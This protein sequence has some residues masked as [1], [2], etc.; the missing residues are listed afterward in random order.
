MRRGAKVIAT[1]IAALTAL[2]SFCLTVGCSDDAKKDDTHTTPLLACNKTEYFDGEEIYIAAKGDGDAWVG[3]YR[4]GDDVSQSAAIRYY[5]VAKNGFVSGGVYALKKASQ[6]SESRQALRN[7]PRGKYY[8]I[9]F[10]S[11]G[12]SKELARI[13]FTVKKEKIKTPSAPLSVRYDLDN[14][15]D[16]L[17]DGKL[18]LRFAPTACAEE[19]VL[20]WADGNGALE[21]YTALAPFYVTGD[22]FEFDMYENTIIPPEATRLLAYGKNSL[23][24]S[25]TYCAV[26]LPSG[27]QYDF[28]DAISEFQVVSDVHITVA[29]EHIANTAIDQ[30]KLHDAHFSGMFDDIKSVSPESGGV[31]VVG[32]IANAGYEYEW[33]HAAELVAA[34][35]APDVYFTLGNHDLYGGPYA[36]RA[37][38]FLK[39]A[40]T[41]KVYY[42][43][44]IDGYHH[45]ALG[46]ESSSNGLDA[47]LSDAQLR[48]FDDRLK[49]I[50]EAAPDKPVF[51][52]LHQSLYNTVAGSFEGQDW[53]GVVQDDKLRAIVKKYPQICMFNGHSH[54]DLNT[55]GSM[56]DRA[57]GLPNIFNTASVGYLWTSY[58]LPKGEYLEGS[59]GYY[60]RIFNGK[61]AVLGRDFVNRKWVPSACFIAS[62]R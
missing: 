28:G 10:E 29:Y 22:K 8:A 12:A 26:D 25:E 48:W 43:R 45:L 38:A 7:L 32:D 9:L 17:A 13:S 23:G 54:W 14:R 21:D 24:L 37:A 2:C 53:D 39:Y 62:I 58:Y 40:N 18:T 4:D 35:N 30:S 3:V 59:Q 34:A 20:Y 41:D 5:D 51:V 60:I 46:S 1:L 42:E 15:T 52:Y 50:T 6:Y 47:D 36:E 16:G 57:D 11:A 31:F 49:A 55:R 33:Q 56:H 44:I 27:C 19:V 61:V